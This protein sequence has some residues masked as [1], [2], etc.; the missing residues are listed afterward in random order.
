MFHAARGTRWRASGT[1]RW[2]AT[3]KAKKILVECDTPYPCPLEHGMVSGIAWHFDAR[4][5]VAH[6][7]PSAAA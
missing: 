5:I 4:A 6:E 7:I 1:T 2:S 3:G